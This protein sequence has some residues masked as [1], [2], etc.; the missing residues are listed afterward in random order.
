MATIT[1][2]RFGK[3]RKLPSG[4]YQASFIGPSGAR[5]T[6]PGTFATKTDANRWLVKVEADLARG[7]WIDEELGR[8]TLG[9]YTRA[10]IRDHPKMGPRYG[11]TCLRNLRLHL[12]RL[13]GLPLLGVTPAVVREWHAAVMRGSGGHTSIAQTYRLLRAVM[14]TAVRDGAIVKNPCQ[15]PGAGTERAKERPIATPAQVGELVDAITPRYRATVLLAAWCGLRRGEVIGLMIEDIDLA[16]GTVTVHRNRVELLETREAFDDDPKTDAG[17][18]TIA[19][20]PHLLPFLVDHMAEWAGK[21][22]VFVGRAGAPM[23]GDAIRQA[24]HRARVKVGMPGFRFHDL[25][26]TGQ[27]LAAATGATLKDL[28]RR[29]GH[30]SP[31]AAQRYLHAVEGRD[32]EIAAALSELAVHG[33]AAKLPRSI[34]VKH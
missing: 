24:F 20:P 4:R 28:M 12:A 3:V 5:Q 15:I 25:R 27:T 7:T 14:N 23:R 6:A 10:W 33:N 16:A 22:R 30:A 32:A 8:E 17:R 21:E 26:H 9:N 13:D 31:V 11:E 18:R 1:R 2:R 34:V 19:I 29:L